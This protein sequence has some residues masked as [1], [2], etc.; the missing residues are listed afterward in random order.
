MV[1][2]LSDD[3]SDRRTFPYVNLT[4]IALNVFVFVVLQRM[5]DDDQFTYAFSTVPRRI[6]TG[7][8]QPI[9]QERDYEHPLTGQRY[10]VKPG[11][12]ATPISVYIT[13]LTSL[14]LHGS[15][16]HIAGN[17]WF[18]Y[19]FGDNVEDFLG[20]GLYL[21][22]YLLCGILASLSHV[23]ATVVFYGI[24]SQEALVPSLGASGAISGVL[25]GYIVLFPQKPVLVSLFWVLTLVPAWVAIGIWFGFQVVSGLPMLGGQDTGGVAYAAHVG[26]FI[27]GVALILPFA[28]GGPAGTQRVPWERPQ[29][30]EGW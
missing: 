29:E 23:F 17:M 12:P 7:D 26:G 3:N 28:A 4:L 30:R 21:V 24:D 18:L 13:L 19:I 10:V 8:N 5:G 15:V 16:L 9:P 14:F 11:L 22:Y 1:F 2:P 6:V 27:S 25:G 20:H